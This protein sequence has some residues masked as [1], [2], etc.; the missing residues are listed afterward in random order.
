[1]YN[2]YKLIRKSAF[3]ITFRLTELLCNFKINIPEKNS[4]WYKITN[5]HKSAFNSFIHSAFDFGWTKKE[6]IWILLTYYKI[7][8]WLSKNLQQGLII[9][10]RPPNCRNSKTGVAILLKSYIWSGHFCVIQLQLNKTLSTVKMAFVEYSWIQCC[11]L[12]CNCVLLSVHFFFF[13][14][15]FPM[16]LH[17]LSWLCNDR[18]SSLAC[19]L[20]S[21][22]T[23]LTAV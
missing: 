19:S 10:F 1:M 20:E 7:L 12:I 8:K 21:W 11:F 15:H 6:I 14:N 17:F 4:Q 9:C 23:E 5:L 18:R 2:F 16:C 3:R 22:D 13:F